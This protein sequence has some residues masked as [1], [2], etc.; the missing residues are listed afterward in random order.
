[1]ERRLS[2]QENR[3]DVARISAPTIGGE[4]FVSRG[5]LLIRRFNFHALRV[6]Q[7]TKMRTRQEADVNHMV[8]EALG[9]LPESKVRPPKEV[10]DQLIQALM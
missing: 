5:D 7:N 10:L 6:R 9:A 4:S 1:M 3:S 2:L 8:D